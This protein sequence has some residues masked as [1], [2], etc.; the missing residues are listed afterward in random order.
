MMFSAAAAPSAEMEDTFSKKQSEQ[1]TQ[2]HNCS[3]LRL[4]QSKLFKH[5]LPQ[6]NIILQGRITI[7]SL[8]VS[9]FS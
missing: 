3:K 1:V 6:K 2:P 8:L 4:L 7:I 9:E 5:W